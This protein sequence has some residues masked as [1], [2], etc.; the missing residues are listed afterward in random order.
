M[1]LKLISIISSPTAE[2]VMAEMQEETPQQ[3]PSVPATVPPLSL[4]SVLSAYDSPVPVRSTP[5]SPLA[6]SYGPESEI[7]SNVIP[8]GAATPAP[9]AAP[10]PL[11]SA[12]LPISRRRSFI[13]GLLALVTPRGSSPSTRDRSELPASHSTLNISAPV[14]TVPQ[15]EDPDLYYGAVGLFGERRVPS[16]TGSPGPQPVVSVTAQIS[17]APTRGR[18]SS[19]PSPLLRQESF[20]G[21]V[22]PTGATLP[23]LFQWLIDARGSV[24]I[25]NRSRD[26]Q[27]FI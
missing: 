15:A 7:T 16:R 5:V 10:A 27:T 21:S 23:K 22:M 25:P 11:S 13:G 8:S 18:S 17:A 12:R 3:Q 4:G 6:E 14:S 1:V 9:A 20:T 24:G 19:S 2:Q 26:T